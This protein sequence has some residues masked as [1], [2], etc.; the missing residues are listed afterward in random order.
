MNILILSAYDAESHKSWRLGLVAA[1]PEYSFTVL[2]LPPR[3][4]SW[5]I[6]GNSLS[7]ADSLRQ[8]PCR[9][10]LILATSMVDLSTLMGLV[11]K[12]AAVPSLL[13]F[14]ENQFAFPKTQHAHASLE[15]QMVTLY[16]AL[17]ATT[18]AFNSRYNFD[19]YCQGI[20]DL[21]KRFPDAV[22]SGLV[23]NIRAKSHILPVPLSDDVFNAT[24]SYVVPERGD[25]DPSVVWN[26]RWEYDKGPDRL[27]A[28]LN[29]LPRDLRVK[30]HIVG[31]RFKQCPDEMDQIHQLLRER[32]WLG[33]WG[34][35]AS[36]HRYLDC[37]SE[38]DVVLSTAIHDFQGLSVLEAM[39]RGCFP[40]APDRLAY[41][42]YVDSAFR[43]RAFSDDRDA[44]A[45]A[46]A[47]T[48]VSVL[49]SV[50]AA[51]GA[52]PSASAKSYRWQ[53]LR[54]DYQSAFSLTLENA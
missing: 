12:L 48:L 52:R 8:D 29:A 31:Q 16:S 34:P 14:H 19:T 22:P 32:G 37:L 23:D 41:P 7:F 42:E 54:K 36:R 30:F 9:Y 38:A 24:H 2:T 53:V 13:Y 45:S 5:R 44:E 46:A 40:V 33:Q 11:P 18:L 17:S 35:I 50:D 15:P 1:F 21:L 49:G 4:F 26:H 47:E 3:Y 43:Y 27:L 6:R 51:S 28:L 25:R 20:R 39:A 10:D